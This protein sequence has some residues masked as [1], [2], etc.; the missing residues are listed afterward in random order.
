MS[1]LRTENINRESIST[2]TDHDHS[3][4]KPILG[5]NLADIKYLLTMW[6][7]L[8]RDLNQKSR[9]LVV[10][11]LNRLVIMPRAH[12]EEVVALI[13]HI[14]DLLGFERG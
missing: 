11:Y 5:R 9:V 13:V 2:F 4:S 12:Q 7:N 1:S 14:V 8:S 6:L 10:E 3:A